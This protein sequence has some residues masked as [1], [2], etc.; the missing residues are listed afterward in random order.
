VNIPNYL[1]KETQIRIMIQVGLLPL[2]IELE[3]DG[4]RISL[5]GGMEVERKS[6]RLDAEK[7]RRRIRGR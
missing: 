3:R 1:K 4:Q 7:K 6:N 5:H 2:M